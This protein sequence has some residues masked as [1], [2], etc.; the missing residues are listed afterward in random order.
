MTYQDSLKSFFKKNALA[1]ACCKDP[2]TTFHI[3]A[4]NQKRIIEEVLDGE[5]IH[6]KDGGKIN[7]DELILEPSYFC[8]ILG[9]QG[10]MDFIDLNLDTIIEQKVVKVH[11]LVMLIRQITSKSI[12]YSCSFI[13]LYFII[14]IRK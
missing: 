14:L 6:K 4:Q 8:G 11:G 12:M 1:F 9:L 7:V 3:E 13:E 2:L 10:R 5:S